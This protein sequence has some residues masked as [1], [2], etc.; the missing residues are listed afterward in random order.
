MKPRLFTCH[1]DGSSSFPG[2]DCN[3]DSLRAQWTPLRADL[4]PGELLGVWHHLTDY[5]D[6]RA[7]SLEQLYIR[8]VR[9]GAESRRGRKSPRSWGPPGLSGERGSGIIKNMGMLMVPER[10]LG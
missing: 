10:M 6:L 5:W 8:E 4:F 9:L 2:G 3:G 1:L 7:E